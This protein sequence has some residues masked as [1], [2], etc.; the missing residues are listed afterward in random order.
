MMKKYTSPVIDIKDFSE[1]DIICVS[2][3]APQFVIGKE[4]NTVNDPSLTGKYSTAP[5]E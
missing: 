1:E 3:A 5:W 2:L 4:D